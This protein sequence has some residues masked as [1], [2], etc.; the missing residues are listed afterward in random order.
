MGRLGKARQR[1][2]MT[3]QSMLEKGLME[4]GRKCLTKR[5]AHEAAVVLMGLAWAL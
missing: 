4:G 5:E 3:E 1:L 2:S